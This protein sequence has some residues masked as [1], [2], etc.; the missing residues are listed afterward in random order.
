MM[1]RPPHH[2]AAFLA[3]AV[4]DDPAGPA[5]LGD[6]HEDFVARHRRGPVRARW[7]Y[8]AQVLHLLAGRALPRLM[9]RRVLG[10]RRAALA[11]DLK[12]ARRAVQRA[13]GLSLL[14]AVVVGVG[15]GAVTTVY[16]VVR[17]LMI[18]SLPV[19]GAERLA[20]IENTEEGSSL[21][22]RTFRAVNLLDFRDRARSFEAMGGYSPFSDQTAWTLEVDGRP[23][24]L[25]GVRV[26][27][28]F[29]QVL[30][31]TPLVGRHFTAEE[32][33]PDGPPA[34]LLSHAFWQRRFA[35]DP[36]VVGRTLRVNGVAREVAGVLPPSF[37]F[38]SFFAPGTR[39][40]FLLPFVVQRNAGWQG[41]IMFFVGRLRP[42]VT[43]QAAEAELG[44]LV[45]AIQEEE[46]D[47]WGL[48]PPRVVPLH[49]HIAA[50][51]RAA[52]A[53]L[54]VAAAAVLL[55]VC[56]NVTNVMLARM[57]R[58][59]RQ[60]AVLKALGATRRRIVR[61]FLL[62]GLLLSLP[63]A[64]LGALLAVAAT[65]VLTRGA[66]LSIPLLERVTVDAS[67]LLVA[68]G[69]ALVAG[70]A[71]GLVPALRVAEGAASDVL[72]AHARGASAHRGGRRLREGLVVGQLAM[73]CVVLTAGGLLLRSFQ[74]VLDVELGYEVSRAV[75]WQLN[76]SR[77]FADQQEKTRFLTGLLEGVAVLPEVEEAALVD[78]LPLG[79]SRSWDFRVVG[80]PREQDTDDEM[81]PHVVS[82]GYLAA[83][84]IRLVGGR[85]FTAEDNA[86]HPPVIVINET[87]ARRM[88]PDG[89]ALGREIVT[90]AP[91]WGWRVVGVVEDVRHSSPEEE[92]GLEVYFAVAQQPDYATMDL[93]VRSRAETDVLAAAVA[94]RLAEVDP[95]MPAWDFWTLEETLE[96][97][98]SPRRFTV[99]AVTAFALV[100]LLLAVLGVY[101]VVTQTV[102]EREREL[103][104]RMA[105]G[106]T[107]RGVRGRV[108]ARTLLLAAAG[109]SAGL[110]VAFPVAGLLR[111]LL[112]GVSPADPMTFAA[113]AVTLLL[114]AVLAGVPASL[115]ASRADAL[116]A[117]RS[118]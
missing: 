24:R 82:T 110:A 73:A 47:R 10:G 87:A 15:V 78:G 27:H 103:G 117:L 19:A 59:A 60:V 88:F 65:S 83:M 39:V 2:A 105:L 58:R 41:N 84:G 43:A 115:R 112:F 113:M 49:S 23:E 18:G 29:L 92:A 64:A 111:S 100:A 61:Q 89:P 91:D 6:L 54:V 51:L 1:P 104:I 37:D 3:R 17:P 4:R 79:R 75:A 5:I 74:A 72:G 106:D 85:G 76:P 31:V 50:P 62:E 13:P 40:D 34:M 33:A 22:E 86:E 11:H 8:R 108:L 30:G 42:G 118:E 35:G 28:D 95:G 26:T 67:A 48:N 9:A 107:P 97:T 94:R 20:W 32:A 52:F 16:S 25:A 21:S 81:F 57:P 93:V 55:L 53:L 68:M 101:G 46:P 71:A 102:A 14:L 63:G 99:Q 77:S 38:A 80:V 116:V 36:G 7:W 12:A 56:L 96:R 90:G 98:L 44:A 45:H 114:A 109:V 69:A 70:I 66:A